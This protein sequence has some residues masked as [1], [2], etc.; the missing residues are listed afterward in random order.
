MKIAYFPNQIAQNAP[1]VLDAFLTSC[2]EL[3]HEPVE[4]SMT[5]DSAVIWSHV[6]SGKM[7][8]NQQVWQTYRKHNKNVFVL[9]V[10]TL[11]RGITWKVGLNGTT[12]VGYFGPNNQDS[13]RVK[14]LG[15][16][17]QPWSTQGNYIL[18]CTQRADSEQWANQPMLE[19]WLDII[20][21]ELHV[22]TPRPIILR[23]HPRFRVNQRWPRV[24]IWNPTKLSGTYDCYD[25]DVAF[26]NAWAVVNWNSG[27]G[28]AAVMQGI[29]AFVGAS[30][31]AAPVANLALKNIENPKR[32]DRQQWLNDLAYTEWTV[33]EIARGLPLARLV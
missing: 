18:I 26:K 14:K 29:P 22:H 8:K 5:A 19:K 4:N 24:E 30:S 21:K 17:L 12:G 20:I 3:G 27:P 28:V 31:L 2:R 33:E 7:R 13:F 15:L 11:K 25:I 10:G 16:T 23:P 1:A 9:E 6:W 32:P